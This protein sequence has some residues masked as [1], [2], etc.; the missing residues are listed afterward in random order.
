MKIPGLTCKSAHNTTCF[1]CVLQTTGSLESCYAFKH[2]VTGNEE[3]VDCSKAE[4]NECC[5]GGLM[6]DA[7]KYIGKAK[8]LCSE[9]EYKYMGRDG[10]CKVGNFVLAR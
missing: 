6:D 3:L 1:L 4:G 5:N 9:S 8:G 2:S 7:F 10:T